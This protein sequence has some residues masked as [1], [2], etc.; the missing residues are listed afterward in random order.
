[1]I[2]R[3]LIRGELQILNLFQ[4]SRSIVEIYFLREKLKLQVESCVNFVD[5]YRSQTS[6]KQTVH[7]I[8]M[9]IRSYPVLKHNVSISLCGK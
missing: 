7:Q 2:R 9:I 1:M 5:V 3:P 8:E 6:I 4:T